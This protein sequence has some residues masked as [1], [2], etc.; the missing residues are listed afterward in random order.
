MR[1]RMRQVVPTKAKLISLKNTLNLAI[2]GQQLMEK[3]KNILINELFSNLSKMNEIKSNIQNI[4]KIA[5]KSLQDSNITLGNIDIIAKASKIDD[6]INLSFKN[7]MGVDLPIVIYNNKNNYRYNYS[8]SRTNSNLDLTYLNFNE[9]KK[10][11]LLLAEIDNSTFKLANAI[12]KS[13][14]RA[15]SLKNV[16]IPNLKKQIKQ[17]ENAIE[18][19]EREE[20]IRLKIIKNKA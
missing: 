20:F 9:V 13:Q 16:V 15:N 4:F 6:N 2:K 10:N 5:Y 11:L 17:I 7:V 1:L 8:I 19:K 18:E 12:N 3:K 14:K